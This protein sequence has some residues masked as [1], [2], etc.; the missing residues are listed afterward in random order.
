MKVIV[1]NFATEYFDEG[2]GPTTLLLHGW[3]DS[4][5]TFDS[6]VSTLSRDFRIIRVDLPGFGGSETPGEPWGVGEYVQFVKAFTKKIDISVDILIGHSFGGR[7]V[8]KGVGD[9]DLQ[10]RKIVLIGAAGLAKH[11]TLRSRM[12]K[13]FAKIGGAVFSPFPE[14]MQVKLRRKLYKRVGSEDYL[15]SGALKETF[16]K[17]TKEDLSDIARKIKIPALLIWG[18]NDKATPLSDGTQLHRLISGSTLEVLGGVG[19]FVHQ[20]RATGVATLVRIFA[21]R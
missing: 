4:S 3:G 10:P 14:S 16:L 19:H 5:R 21:S 18:E 7:I 6:L 12:Y 15:D 8:I 2:I 17:V 20:E 11:S 9:G 13:T 1:N